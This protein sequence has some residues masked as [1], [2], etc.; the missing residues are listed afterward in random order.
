MKKANFYSIMRKDGRVQAVLQNGYSDGTYYYYRSA[1]Y[2]VWHVIQP[3]TGYSILTDRSR[4]KAAERAHA[5]EM[6]AAINRKM[7]M[8]GAALIAKF[9]KLTILAEEI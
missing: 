2:P 5:P 7:E 8:N 1:A 4:K 9:D 3:A 6:I